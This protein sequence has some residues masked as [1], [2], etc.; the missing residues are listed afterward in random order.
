MCCDGVLEGGGAGQLTIPLSEDTG[1]Y[2]CQGE[3][4][5]EYG[6]HDVDL[7]PGMKG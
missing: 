5:E 3:K 4:S 7:C 1:C 6:A 2:E